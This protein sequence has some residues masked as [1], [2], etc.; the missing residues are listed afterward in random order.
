LNSRPTAC[1]SLICRSG[2]G[3][4]PVPG[5][6]FP[7]CGEAQTLPARQISKEL[8]KN[9]PQI[10]EQI[11]FLGKHLSKSSLVKAV[12]IL[13]EARKSRFLRR[14]TPKYGSMNKGF[15]EEEL[16]AFFSVIDEPKARLLFSFQAV[17]GLRIGEAIRVNVNDINLRSREL[18]I[19]TEKSKKT[20]YL[21]IPEKLFD[22]VLRYI[23]TFEKDI[24]RAEGYLFFSFGQGRRTENTEPHITT[25]TARKMFVQYTRKAKLDM[26]YGYSVGEKPKTL[27]RLST[28]SLR[29]HAIT[30]FCRKN[31][32]N[33][34]LASKFA[35]HTDL[36]TTMVYVHTAK[37]ELYESIERANND[38]LLEKVRKMQEGCESQANKVRFKP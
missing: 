38:E 13:S 33:V 30:N 3:G 23:G 10:K 20:D 34:V 15:T 35:R 31:G 9:W 14:K 22:S 5:F 7:A 16:E 21:L 29:H 2:T 19:F 27:Y 4:F 1:Q 11:E 32:G 36:Q 26:A 24:A 28:H 18:R 12:G 17:L 37:N 25:E 8:T 6:Q